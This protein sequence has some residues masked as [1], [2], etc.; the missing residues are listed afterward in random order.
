MPSPNQVTCTIFINK[1]ED[2]YRMS[3]L[4]IKYNKHPKI[5]IVILN[6]NGKTDTKEC[7]NSLKN[8][9]YPNYEIILVDNG[10]VDG[11][12][13]M[14]EKEHPEIM[15]IKN[16]ENLGFTGGN[17]V[18]IKK[19]LE[20]NADYVLLLN[21][22]TIVEPDFLG[23]M[24]GVAEQDASIGIIGPK[25]YYYS[26]PYVI[27]SAGGKY[28]SFLGKARTNGIN[29]TD[30]PE[31]NVQKKV[32]WVTGCAMMIKREVFEKIGLLK[33]QYFSNY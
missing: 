21:N 8:I 15:L 27:W 26:L 28:I 16:K 10:S 12:V 24:V 13:E 29:Q 5:A 18:G 23:T 33:E 19:A 17:N 22:D 7:L 30:G 2:L 1:R 32:S 3:K 25:I 11:S 4:S 9:T 14:L 31:Y 6:W 20:H